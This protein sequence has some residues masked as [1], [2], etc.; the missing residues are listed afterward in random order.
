MKK[1]T[2][3]IKLLVFAFLYSLLLFTPKA[4]SQE[5]IKTDILDPIWVVPDTIIPV[6]LTDII[7]SAEATLTISSEIDKSLPDSAQLSSFN[8]RMEE[9]I[10]SIDSVSLVLK[11]Y[12]LEDIGSGLVRTIKAC[13]LIS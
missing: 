13:S 10:T 7:N 9:L 6:A 2:T 3:T 12:D 4:Y 5:N 1:N 8:I 11:D